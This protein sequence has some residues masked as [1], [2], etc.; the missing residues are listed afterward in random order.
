MLNNEFKLKWK[1]LMLFALL[2]FSVFLIS[3]I[4]AFNI[5]TDEITQTSIVW[6]LS[7]NTGTITEIS[8]D[9][10]IISGFSPNATR[11]VQSG[12]ATGETH[13]ITVI[14]DTETVSEME[15]T[16]LSKPTTQGET[17]FTTINLY[18]LI[19]LSLV[20]MVAAIY[21]RIYFLSFIGSLITIIG[22]VGSFGNNF[23]TGWI[24]GIM[25]CATLWTGF[26][27]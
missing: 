26:N 20:F 15:A 22:I 24:F 8:L 27:T 4:Q 7:E 17:L 2:T 18:I 6:N 19:L 21:T 12:L 11:I 1:I 14:D 13:I 3:P 25:L 16:T 23:I 5:T 9:G 10:V